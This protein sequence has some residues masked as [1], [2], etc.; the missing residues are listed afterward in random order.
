MLI[1]KLDT[2]ISFSSL[3]G[4]YRSYKR[5][6]K[7][8]TT[9]FHLAGLTLYFYLFSLMLKILVLMIVRNSQYLEGYVTLFSPKVLVFKMPN[10]QKKLKEQYNKFL[11]TFYLDSQMVNF[12]ATFAFS[13]LFLLSHLETSYM[14]IH[15]LHVSSRTRTFSYKITIPWSDPRNLILI[16]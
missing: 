10:L 15:H 3:Q 16:L 13:L 6:F 1:G 11:C 5:L 12:F 8:K 7:F 14:T 9:K 2:R 4:L